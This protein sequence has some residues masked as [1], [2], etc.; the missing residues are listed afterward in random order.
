M[1]LEDFMV[2]FFPA[3]QDVTVDARQ[4]Q[5]VMKMMKEYESIILKQQ[6]VIDN[7][8]TCLDFLRDQLDDFKNGKFKV[9]LRG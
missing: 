7:Q 8:N 6:K 2:D 4:L 3:N 1:G 9:D 5:E